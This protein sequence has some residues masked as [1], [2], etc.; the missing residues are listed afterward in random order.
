MQPGDIAGSELW[1]LPP[2]SPLALPPLPPPPEPDNRQSEY[3]LQDDN[4][5][6][7]DWPLKPVEIACWHSH[8]EV[9]RR[10]ADGDDEVAIVFED[11][12]DMEWDLDRRLRRIWPFLPEEWDMVMLGHCQSAEFR[13]KPVPG[14]TYLYPSSFTMCSHAYAVSKKS[15]AHLV[16]LMRTPLHAYARPI[17]HAIIY[18]NDHKHIN[19]YSIYPPPVIQAGRTAGDITG[20]IG[21]GEF[22]L[23]DSALDRVTMWESRKQV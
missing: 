10:I 2:S 21:P 23:M 19:Q 15:A 12:V 3:V 11:D 13:K 22:F 5:P 14:T 16:R 8:F 7:P 20:G 18:W 1:F 9:L 4:R 6:N 17:D